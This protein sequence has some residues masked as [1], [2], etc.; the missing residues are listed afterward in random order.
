MNRNIVRTIFFATLLL[1]LAEV[2]SAQNPIAYCT[3]VTVAGTWGYTET[4]TMILPAPVGAIPYA[5][6]G[7]Y[8]LDFNGNVSGERTASAGGTIIKATIKGTATVNPDCT[9]TLTVSFYDQSGNSA[10]SAVKAVVY[11]NNATEA[12]MI[13]TSTSYPVVLTTDAKKL[14]PNDYGR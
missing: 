5:S 7:N 1:S 12:R 6:V 2:A 4:G 9:G 13:I 3:N 11:V 10:G 14:F 8:T